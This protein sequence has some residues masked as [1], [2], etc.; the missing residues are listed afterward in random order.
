MREI[1]RTFFSKQA[2]IWLLIAVMLVAAGCQAVGGLDL[3]RALLNDLELKSAQQNLTM[4]LKFKVDP[5]KTLDDSTK[6]MMEWLDNATLEMDQ[7][8]M[9][10]QEVVSL[11][12]QLKLSKGSIPFH[13]YVGA[14]ETVLQADGLNRTIVLPYGMS[15][16]NGMDGAEELFAQLQQSFLEQYKEKGLDKAI[17]S[18]IVN[19]LPNPKSISVNSLSETIRGESLNVYRVE[20]NIAGSEMIPLAKTFLRNTTKDDAGLKSLV[21]Q[22]Y[23]AFWPIVEPLLKEEIKNSE[24]AAYPSEGGAVMKS[25]LDAGNDRELAIDILH[26][27]LKELAFVGLIGID[28]LN[29]SQDE[30]LQAVLGNNTYINSKLYFDRQFQLRKSDV[31]LSIGLPSAVSGGIEAIQLDMVSEIWDRNQPVKADV[32]EKGS[33]PFI[34]DESAMYGQDAADLIDPESLLGQLGA[35]NPAP[36]VPAQPE[37]SWKEPLYLPLQSKDA[38]DLQG[39]Y[40][41]DSVSYGPLPVLAEY[42]DA[43]VARDGDDI[44]VTD[45]WGELKFK[46]DSAELLVDGDPFELQGAVRVHGDVVYVPVRDVAEWL[47]AYVWFDGEGQRIGI[48]QDYFAQPEVQ[49]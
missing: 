40:L 28:T 19:N 43:S 5:S 12:G 30:S 15:G 35:I 39:A 10:S 26:T 45:A 36:S 32:L 42:L 16:L 46:V 25:V 4:T 17:S 18:F 41:E 7:I 6:Q 38:Q 21:G 37:P 9:E 14:N 23:D 1:I 31:K 49:E 27:T 3:N 24:G 22:L 34:I 48:S 20:A 44:I 11:K 47:G 33:N 8:K 13:L 2:A 29:H